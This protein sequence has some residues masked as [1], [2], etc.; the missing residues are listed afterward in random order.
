MEFAIFRNCI[1][2]MGLYK[3]YTN[4]AHQHFDVYN[5]T[6][7]YVYSH[8]HGEIVNPKNRI[9]VTPWILFAIF[10]MGP[11]E[12]IV[13]LLFYSGATRSMLEIILLITVFTITTVLSMVAMVLIGYYGNS[14][15]KTDLLERYSYAISGA[16]VTICAC[17]MLFLNW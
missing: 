12:P 13:P 8:K 11:S 10:V 2:N 4:K 9:K 6:D 16:V 3:A 5:D 17:G 7:V 14:F 1:F 15:I